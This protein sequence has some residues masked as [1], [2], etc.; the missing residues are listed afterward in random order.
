M[1]LNRTAWKIVE[2]RVRASAYTRFVTGTLIRLSI[3]LGMLPHHATG[4]L[5]AG[6]RECAK[7]R[8]EQKSYPPHVS[9]RHCPPTNSTYP[10]KLAGAGYPR[11]PP[12]H[13]TYI[14][15]ALETGS[16]AQGFISVVFHYHPTERSR[17][18][19]LEAMKLALLKLNL[20][21]F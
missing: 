14:F 11:R 12:V 1:D 15:L 20:I 16:Y 3:L 18:F 17:N 19:I 10:D 2:G 21:A 5:D 8:P 9:S 13:F 7:P 4:F 6:P